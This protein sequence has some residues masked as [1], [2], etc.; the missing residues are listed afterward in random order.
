MLNFC[1]SLQKKMYFQIL[2]NLILWI[3]FEKIAIQ[4]SPG[5]AKPKL[6]SQGLKQITISYSIICKIA[7]F[8]LVFPHKYDQ[9]KASGWANCSKMFGKFCAKRSVSNEVLTELFAP[10]FGGPDVSAD[11]FVRSRYASR[12]F[13][14]FRV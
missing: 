14:V 8:S 6:C 4:F 2:K 5:F 1:K 7:I 11:F 10:S 12:R 13:R 3:Y 9:L